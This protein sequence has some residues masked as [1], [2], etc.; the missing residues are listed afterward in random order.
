MKRLVIIL[1]C[2]MCVMSMNSQ[3]HLKFYNIPIDG[4]L[5]NAVKLVKKELGLKG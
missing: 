3:E 5:K 2:M 4:E 1:A